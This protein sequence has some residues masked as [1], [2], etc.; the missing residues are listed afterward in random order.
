MSEASAGLEQLLR[1]ARMGDGTALGQLLELYR[2]YLVVL[3]RVQIGRRLQGKVDASDVVQSAFLKAHRHFGQFRGQSE[4]E[5]AAW[6][7]QILLSHLINVVRHY[8][9]TGRRDPRLERDLA[10]ELDQSSRDLDRALFARQGTPS[11]NVCKREQAVLLSDALGRLPEDYREV[12]ILR[13]LEDLPFKEVAVRMGKSLDSV[14]KLW[15]RALARLRKL[16]REE[17]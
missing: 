9:G 12:I 16:M 13:H 8:H 4:K 1:L 11:Q 17:S 7:R 15:V 3:T 2:N 5:L 14:D 10:V 6:L